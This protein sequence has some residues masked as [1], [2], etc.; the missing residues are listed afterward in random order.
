MS[1]QVKAISCMEIFPSDTLD[2][3]GS[4]W[5]CCVSLNSF[6]V[7]VTLISSTISILFFSQHTPVILLFFN[8]IQ[9][10]ITIIQTSI[11]TEENYI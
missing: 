11:K 6:S 4:L 2:I 10:K 3:L 9:K 1:S 5:L 7:R 8:C